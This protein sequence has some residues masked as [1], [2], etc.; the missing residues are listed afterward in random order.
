MVKRYLVSYDIADPERLRRVYGVVKT[1]AQR[2]QDSVYEALLTERELVLLE[3]RIAD[4]MNQ[5]ED[6]V[7]FIDLGAGDRET[8]SEVKTLGVPWRLERR[9]SIVV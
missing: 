2:V 4:V 6:Q 8:L 3:K 1:M 7:L 9:G 5:K